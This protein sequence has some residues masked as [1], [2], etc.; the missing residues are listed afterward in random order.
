M[1]ECVRLHIKYANKTYLDFHTNILL[2]SPF[3][4]WFTRLILIIII[5]AGITI[6]AARNTNITKPVI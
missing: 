3:R 5:I 4:I 2:Y 1:V 6:L